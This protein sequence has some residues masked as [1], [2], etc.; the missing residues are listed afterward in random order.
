MFENT[1]KGTKYYKIGPKK[2]LEN[3]K[4]HKIL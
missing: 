2:R 1:K 3:T 4:R